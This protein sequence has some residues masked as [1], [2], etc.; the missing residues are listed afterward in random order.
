MVGLV[1][2]LNQFANSVVHLRMVHALLGPAC[3]SGGSGPFLQIVSN[4]VL[5]RMFC[6]SE[7]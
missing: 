6:A 5:E 2:P 7:A 3:H 4:Y 1:I